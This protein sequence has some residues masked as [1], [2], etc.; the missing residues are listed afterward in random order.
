MSQTSRKPFVDFAAIKRAVTIRQIL[1]HYDLLDQLKPS[2]T[3]AL[4]GCCPIHKGDNPKQFSVSLSKNCWNCFSD[5][6]CGGN[7]L[8]F[9]AHMEQ[10]DVHGAAVLI[11]DWFDLDLARKPD[12]TKKHAK[13]STNDSSEVAIAS[14]AKPP[15]EAREPEP[16]EEAPAEP[17]EPNAPLGFALK[18]L[19]NEHD[20]FSEREIDS[21]TVAHFELGFCKR[22]TMA[23]RIVIPIHNAEGDLVGYVGRWPG[24]PPEERPKYKLPKGFHKLSEVYNLHR[25][26]EESDGPLVVV[27]G[28]FDCFALWQAGIRRVVALMGSH[29]SPMQEELIT[30]AI[31]RSD[32]IELLFDQD[33]AGRAGREKAVNRLS[34]IA[35]VRVVELPE[36]GMQPSD[37]SAEKLTG[38]FE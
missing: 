38:L 19:E 32:R 29:L 12:S 18:N 24:E 36:E 28:F 31:S 33:K 15:S 3:D 26:R 13:S 27:E 37:L 11:N 7:I 4:R 17:S 8:D 20:Y 21:E 14:E 6:Q 34:R 2:G 35:Y 30:R 25:I 10:T 16:D 5:C 22:G 23:G 9:V 1:E